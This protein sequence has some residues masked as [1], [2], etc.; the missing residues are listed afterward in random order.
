MAF[1]GKKSD[2]K[3]RYFKGFDNLIPTL[4]ALSSTKELI[5]FA[6]G[7]NFVTFGNSAIGGLDGDF[8]TFEAAV[9]AN[10]TNLIQVGSVLETTSPTLQN[11]KFYNVFSLSKDYVL[12][13]DDNVFN[14]STNSVITF[15][16]V[17]VSTNWT[18]AKFLF[19][20][21]YTGEFYFKNCKLRLGTNTSLAGLVDNH[22][23][24]NSELIN[25]EITFGG[26]YSYEFAKTTYLNL[27]NCVII[28]D[29]G[30]VAWNSALYGNCEGIE[31]F[32]VSAGTFGN[33]RFGGQVNSNFK[34][35]AGVTINQLTFSDSTGIMTG[36]NI[37]CPGCGLVSLSGS[38]RMYN[39]IAESCDFGG[40]NDRALIDG[41]EFS[42]T[43]AIA[44]DKQNKSLLNI[45]S[46]GS[47][48]LAVGSGYCTV[49]GIR[50][51]TNKDIVVRTDYNIVNENWIGTTNGGS[52]N[53][54]V[55][56]N[57]NICKDN[58]MEDFDPALHDTG[59]NN[60]ITYKLY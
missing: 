57:N 10:H 20:S 7:L 43:S 24:T 2:Y 5:E 48:D 54:N 40:N 27:T 52:G 6:K 16:G 28:A 42:S 13:F 50:L 23:A 55:Q 26:G 29:G 56:G 59:I 33:L 45:Y 8:S 47:I 12:N 49:K 14:A 46:A 21:G 37:N 18:S 60:D 19:P 58:Y 22:G 41:G 38:I 39:V 36:H 25:T 17:N 30:S 35:L 4:L 15:T 11:G 44:I 31:F 1:N 51:I 9:N 3:Q 53:L 32:T 34:A